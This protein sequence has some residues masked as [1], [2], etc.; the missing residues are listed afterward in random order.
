MNSDSATPTITSGIGMIGAGFHATSNVLPSV[1]L[2]GLPI[3]ALATRDTARSAAALLRFGSDG[4]AVA[5]ADA[6]LADP[7]IRDVVI[8]AQPADQAELTLAA[9]RAGKNAFVDK[10]LGRTPAEARQIAEEADANGVIVMVGFMKRYAPAYR[11]LKTLL[12]RGDLG[13]IRSFE[14]SFGCDS[15]PFCADDEEYLLLAAIHLIDLVRFLFGEVEVAHTLSASEGPNVSLAITLRTSAGVVGALALSG[16]PAYSSETETLRVSGDRGYARVSE[17]AHLTTHL[18][19]PGDVASWRELTEV[20]TTRS[21]AESAM[22]GVERDLHLRGFVGEL[23]AFRTAVD[24]QVAPSS[25][26]RD[27]VRT[28]ELLALLQAG[29]AASREGRG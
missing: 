10:P 17:V 24:S 18:Q 5:G 7:S 9:I 4:R 22:S 6:I 1:V 26:A 15:T 25:S 19:Q 16:L 20:T 3:V 12:E 14:I 2:A 23:L 13:A 11:E 27:N 29:A 28:M 21:P 8:V